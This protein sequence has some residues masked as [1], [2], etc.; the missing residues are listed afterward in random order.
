MNLMR[1]RWKADPSK[2]TP[3]V[4]ST[5]LELAEDGPWGQR[6]W[7]K[8]RRAHS[9]L[10]R[11]VGFRVNMK[12]TKDLQSHKEDTYHEDMLESPEASLVQACLGDGSL[13]LL[14][15]LFLLDPTGDIHLVTSGHRSTSS[16][17]RATRSHVA[18]S[19]HRPKPSAT[20]RHTAR[21]MRVKTVL[22][23][24]H[25]LERDEPRTKHRPRT[26]VPAQG[27]VAGSLGSEV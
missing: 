15:V 11:I 14:P 19:T 2:T 24:N 4:Q 23:P 20:G 9:Q 8:G 1:R 25:S 6:A 26:D 12:P 16:H 18:R 17:D 27:R 13:Q 5:A 3:S 10:K 7:N 21:R 22:G